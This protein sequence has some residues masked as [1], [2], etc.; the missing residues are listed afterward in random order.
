MKKNY[1][2]FALLFVFSFMLVASAE[3]IP[4]PP[5][6]VAGTVTVSGG[7]LDGCTAVLSTGASQSVVGGTYLFNVSIYDADD[8]PTGI[9]VGDTVTVSIKKDGSTL[10]SDSFVVEVGGMDVINFTVYIEPD[11]YVLT[12]STVGQGS[13]SP[14]GG[15]YDDGTIVPLTASPDPGS[16]FDHW[17]GDVSGTSA[18][19]QVTMDSNKSVVAYFTEIPGPVALLNIDIDGA[20]SLNEGY[21][22]QYT[23]T[24]HYSDGSTASVSPAWSENSGYAS[25]SSSGYLS[26][27]NVPSDQVCR[28]TAVFGGK[29]DTHNVNIR[30]TS[31][32]PP[33]IEITKLYFPHSACSAYWETEI[34]VINTDLG[35]TITGTLVAYNHLGSEIDSM[36]VSLHANGR[37]EV[38]VSQSFESPEDIA[39]LIFE[40]ESD[41]AKGYTK[42]WIE[43]VYR[44]AVP[45]VR[46]LNEDEVYISHIASTK[47]WWTGIAL[48][49]T[50]AYAKTLTIV[51]DDGRT[52]W[53]SLAAYEQRAFSIASL[54]DGQIQSDLSS[55]V[56]QNASGIIG[57]E[58]FGSKGA[59]AQQLSGVIL[60]SA[61]ETEIYYPHLASDNYW[62]T[63]FVAYNPSDDDCELVIHRY[64]ADGFVFPELITENIGP[65][66]KFV[67]AVRSLSYLYNPGI[68][69]MKIVSSTPITGFELFGSTDNGLLA[70]YTGAG[71]SS[72]N[73]IFP[74][75]EKNGWTGIAFVNPGS[76]VNNVVLK[77]YSDD[78]NLLGIENLSLNPFSKKVGI[79][80]DLFSDD[81]SDATYVTYTAD[82]DIVGF[83][84]NCSGDSMLDA[85]P[86]M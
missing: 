36:D 72:K 73:G 48:V 34:A 61:L 31:V 37:K 63:G 30:D 43:G 54:F 19:T 68:E 58:L 64:C 50:N 8:N 5:H 77:A 75:L 86:G 53:M 39:Y 52:V 17:G 14:N 4:L 20:T 45:A 65:G 44:V 28:I 24:G 42:F 57:L 40:S 62:W 60:K 18:T 67:S 80:E 79:A 25:I 2:L 55:A 6:R 23:C 84:L 33:P 70:G 22:A 21:G 35:N 47:Q 9:P 71:I 41:K 83:Q 29:T 10:D 27:S 49:N 82:S 11:Q 13:V 16:I 76:Q 46:E 81:I 85:L 66:Q 12:T 74:K 1:L 51:F 26:T 15:T 7:T 56:I 78:G 69:W 59:N 38:L 3:A 32:V